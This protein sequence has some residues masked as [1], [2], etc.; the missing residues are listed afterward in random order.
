ME[1]LNQQHEQELSAEQ[2]NEQKEKMLMF[3]T[4]SL[5]YLKAQLEYENILLQIDESR[6]KRTN[7]Q[8]N[9]A[10]MMNQQEES[11]E[12]IESDDKAQTKTPIQTKKQLKK[13]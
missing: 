12:T 11:D 6:F 4:E 10:M 9:L 2:L 7:I 8:Y 1:N 13:E 5:P 3:Y